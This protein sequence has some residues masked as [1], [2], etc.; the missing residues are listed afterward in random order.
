MEIQDLTFE[1]GQ[2]LIPGATA[3]L[4]MVCA[5]DIDTFPGYLTTT[6]TGDSITLDGNIVLKANKKFAAVDVVVD[7][8]DLTHTLVGVR[9]SKNYTNKIDGKAAKTKAA[10]EWFEKNKNACIVCI[11]EE[12]DGA[13]RV[14][15][16]DKIPA[17]LD[18][19]EGKIGTSNESEKSW[20]FS[21]MDSTG[22]VAPYYTGTIDLDPLT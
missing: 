12:K 14:I 3:K 5:C 15:G 10:D 22:K 21:I 11:L 19:A 18:T 17:F 16:T 8:V 6:G 4:Y 7:S 13:K 1:C 20:I 2:G 9:T